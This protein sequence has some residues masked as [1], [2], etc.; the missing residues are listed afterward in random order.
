[1]A[2]NPIKQG[3]QSEAVD[4]ETVTRIGSVFGR[5]DFT[6]LVVKLVRGGLKRLF[7]LFNDAL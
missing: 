6:G 2:L 5:F 1:M 3:A 7:D 4:G